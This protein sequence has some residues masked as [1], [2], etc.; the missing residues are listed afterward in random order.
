MWVASPLA[1]R[2]LERL[3]ICFWLRGG[4]CCFLSNFFG[5][6]GGVRAKPPGAGDAQWVASPLAACGWTDLLFVFCIVGE[7]FVFGN[8]C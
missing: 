6:W 4:V 1:A 7:F 5:S 2:G 8:F 3:V